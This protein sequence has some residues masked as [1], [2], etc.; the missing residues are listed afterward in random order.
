MN[1]GIVGL[2]LIGGS[3]AK[4]IKENTKHKVFGADLIESVKKKAVL[5]EAIDGE[6]T[7]ENLCLCDMV[8][9]ALYPS[10]TV[11]YIK[12][13]GGFFGKGALVVDCCGVKEYVVGEIQ[14]V[15]EKHGF[16]FV[17]GHPMAGIE[18]SGFAYAQ[19]ALFQ[20]AYMILTPP[21]GIEIHRLGEIKA[22]WLKLGFKDVVIS[23]PQTHDRLI[24]FTSQLAHVVSS[25]YVKSPAALEH[26]GYSAGSFKDLTRVAR[27]NPD[28]WSELFL[29]NRENLTREIDQVIENLCDYREA[30][31][32]GDGEQLHRLLREGTKKKAEADLLL[33]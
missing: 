24:A 14:P 22:F 28:M 2:G 20:N 6:L 25:A 30:I 1:I 15:A 26:K 27:L 10:D 31:R 23:T 29:L 8:I 11:A 21:P 5:L 17:G 12:A 3:I 13:H 33:S 32:G 18:Y 16:L 9:V 4:A 7:K 19:K